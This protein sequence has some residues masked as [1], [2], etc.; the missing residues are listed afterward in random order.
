M[1]ISILEKLAFLAKSSLT[2]GTKSMDL[3]KMLLSNIMW[4]IIYNMLSYLIFH[5]GDKG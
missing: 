1:L 2:R 3:V 4:N 5:G